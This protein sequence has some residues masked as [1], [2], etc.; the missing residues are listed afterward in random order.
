MLLKSKSK[1]MRFL[2]PLNK[3]FEIASNLLLSKDRLNKF[4][5]FSK[6]F[7]SISNNPKPETVS[8]VSD[9]KWLLIFGGRK[10][11]YWLDIVRFLISLLLNAFPSSSLT[12]SIKERRNW[13][14]QLPSFFL[15]NV[16]IFGYVMNISKRRLKTC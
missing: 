1:L 8:R 4:V 12:S 3:S 15:R 6:T 16:L 7:E 9:E 5:M 2:R 11:I 13:T 10:S 14:L